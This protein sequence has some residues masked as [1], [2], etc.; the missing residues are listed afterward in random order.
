VRPGRHARALELFLANL[1]ERDAARQMLDDI[2]LDGYTAL[3]DKGFAG[4]EFKAF[5]AD[6]DANLLR[7]DRKDEPVHYGALGAIRQWIESVFWTCKGQLTPRT[8]RRPHPHR[9]GRPHRAAAARARHR[10]VAQQPHRPTRTATRHL[11]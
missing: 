2:E 8:P 11:H 1:C 3:A 7:P 4:E 6:L 5:M 9:P 10:P